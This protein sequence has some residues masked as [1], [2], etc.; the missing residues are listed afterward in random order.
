[1]WASAFL[2]CSLLFPKPTLTIK[3]STSF[4]LDLISWNGIYIGK[5]QVYD[6]LLGYCVDGLKPGSSDTKKVDP[7]TDYILFWFTTPGPKYRTTELVTVKK[8]EQKTLTFTDSTI[9]QQNNS[10]APTQPMSEVVI[11]EGISNEAKVKEQ[12]EF[13]RRN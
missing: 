11:G 12:M 9:I 13:E 2:G 3:N 8:N 6:Q 10:T 4:E 7:S 5:D 1:V